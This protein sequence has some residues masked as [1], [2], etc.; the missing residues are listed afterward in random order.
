MIIPDTVKI[1]AHTYRIVKRQM[2]DSFGEYDDQTSIITIDNTK[3]QSLQEETLIHEVLHVIRQQLGVELQGEDEEKVVQ[4]L[5]HAIY[6]FLKDNKL[7]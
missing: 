3:P 7:I 1:G 6:Q 4:P 5:G 2:D